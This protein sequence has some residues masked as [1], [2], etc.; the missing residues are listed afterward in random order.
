MRELENARFESLF[1]S[2]FLAHKWADG[3]ELNAQLRES[4]LE[5]EGRHAGEERTKFGGWHSESGHLKFC[6]KAGERLIRHMGEMTEEAMLRVYTE[7][8]RPREP[9]SWTLNAWANIN[10]RGDFNQTHTHPGATWSGVY[11]RRFRRN[12]C[13]RRRDG[14]ASLRPQPGARQSLSSG[15]VEFGRP[16][17]AGTRPDD[18]VSKLCAAFRSAALGRRRAH[19]DRLQRAQGALPL[20]LRLSA[21]PRASHRG[22]H[23]SQ[24]GRGHAGRNRPMNRRTHRVRGWPCREDREPVRSC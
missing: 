10:R 5:H 2:P 19:L 13:Q 3:P 12:E 14:P 20:R 23:R 8:S 11:V 4:I 21:P 18:P 7:F 17:Q 15:A 22:G 24:P 9:L 16:H 6:G 1:A